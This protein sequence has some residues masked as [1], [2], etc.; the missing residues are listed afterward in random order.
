MPR[1]FHTV[2]TRCANSDTTTAILAGSPFVLQ[3]SFS[4]YCFGIMTPFTREAAALKKDRSSGAGT[5]VEGKALN[6]GNNARKGI[7]LRRL[8]WLYLHRPVLF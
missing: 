4:G 8:C 3:L 1:F 2:G 6:I 5:I 7:L